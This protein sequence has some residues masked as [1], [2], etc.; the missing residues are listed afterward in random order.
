M[1]KLLLGVL[2]L[3]FLFIYWCPLTGM[4]FMKLLGRE[5]ILADSVADPDSCT[6]SLWDAVC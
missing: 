5:R 4:L 3:L 1:R 2:P 6:D